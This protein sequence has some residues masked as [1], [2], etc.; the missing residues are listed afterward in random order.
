MVFLVPLLTSVFVYIGKTA[1]GRLRV[2]IL[3]LVCAA[4]LFI[5][6]GFISAIRAV[7]VKASQTL[8]LSSVRCHAVFPGGKLK[9]LREV[10]ITPL[11]RR[12]A[13][14]RQGSHSAIAQ[15]GAA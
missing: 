1:S 7:G 6:L 2:T 14:C 15:H 8:S 11:A 5:L 10:C 3:V 4:G 13:S 9:S 12:F